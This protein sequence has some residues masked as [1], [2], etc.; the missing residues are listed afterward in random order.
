MTYVAATFVNHGQG[1]ITLLGSKDFTLIHSSKCCNS[2][3][4][5]NKLSVAIS[6]GKAAGNSIFTDLLAENIIKSAKSITSS[7]VRDCAHRLGT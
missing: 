4:V 6:L 2:V 3:S 1:P 5:G 7:N